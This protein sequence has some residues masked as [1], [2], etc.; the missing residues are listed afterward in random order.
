MLG[1]YPKKGSPGAIGK[2]LRS[3]LTLNVWDI[4]AVYAL[5]REDDLVYVGEGKLGSRLLSHWRHDLLAGRWDVF[6]WVS[7]WSVENPDR[8][9]DEKAKLKEPSQESVEFNA[10][11]LGEVLELVLVRLANP[12]SNAQLP[13][14]DQQIK[15]LTQRPSEHVDMTPESVATHIPEIAAALHRLEER[16]NAGEK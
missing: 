11:K 2:K 6:S 13:K 5:H 12:R 15:W 8:N 1:Y 7:P 9:G 3:R 4:D 14:M 16:M 10:K